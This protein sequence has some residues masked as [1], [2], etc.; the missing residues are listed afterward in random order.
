MYK[1][2]LLF[3][4]LIFQQY[5]SYNYSYITFDLKKYINNSLNYDDPS[6]LINYDLYS[7]Y[8]T[9]LIFGTPEKKYTMQISL[10]NYGFDLAKY[11]CDI[12]TN[13]TDDE[14]FNPYYSNSSLVEISGINFTYYGLN[15][16]YR[17]TDHITL[18]QNNTLNIFFPN[19]I[20]YYDPRNISIAK[21]KQDFSPFTCFKLGLRLPSENL[22]QYKDYDI[23]IIGQFYRKKIINSYEWFIEYNN[24]LNPKLIIGVEPFI[25]NKNK[26]SYN[27][28]K[29]I[30]GKSIYLIGGD[31]YWKIEFTQIYFLINQKR[32]LIGVRKASLEA[33]FN[34]IKGRMDYFKFINETFFNNFFEQNKCFISN[35]R[36]SI[37]KKFY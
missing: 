21:Y 9:E 3:F 2:F 13:L 22:N 7:F 27:N 23:N 24:D 29:K 37:K 5:Y 28:S 8:S 17:I 30:E 11:K 25:Y 19:I 36:I 10:D 34:F 4:I 31:Y 1:I 20:F 32:E 6:D 14:Y 16:I 18:Y 33:S 12:E 26:Y 15:D 35:Y